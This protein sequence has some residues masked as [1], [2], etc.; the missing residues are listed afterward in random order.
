MHVLEHIS[1][2]RLVQK[3]QVNV[4]MTM[5][6][7]LTVKSVSIMSSPSEPEYEL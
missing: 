3:M 2:V 1:I 4:T 6:I 5:W 7:Q